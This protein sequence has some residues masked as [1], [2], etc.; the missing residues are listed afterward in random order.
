M[1]WYFLQ[2]LKLYAWEDSFRDNIQATRSGE[3]GHL[4][5][6]SYLNAAMYLFMY[7]NAFVVSHKI[8]HTFQ[9]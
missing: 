4:R 9:L 2:V 8:Y 7:L 6:V 5:K 1:V 3:M